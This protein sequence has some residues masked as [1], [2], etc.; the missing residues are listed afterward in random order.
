[1]FQRAKENWN[2][3][4]DL[5]RILREQLGPPIPPPSSETSDYRF[6]RAHLPQALV[7]VLMVVLLVFAGWS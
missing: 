7:T 6:S 1:M 5:D 2:A 3:V 4:V